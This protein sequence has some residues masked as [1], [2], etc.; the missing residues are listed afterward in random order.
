MTCRYVGHLK[1]R[2]LKDQLAK[3]P[4]EVIR[5]AVRR[6][7]PRNKLRDVRITRDQS[8]CPLNLI[9]FSCFKLASTWFS[10]FLLD[11]QILISSFAFMF[12]LY[13]YC[14]QDF[15]APTNSLNAG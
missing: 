3:D 15:I 2:S 12:L 4:T 6:M 5:K 7:L 13:C 1:E 11:V 8:K 10:S 9:F 14:V